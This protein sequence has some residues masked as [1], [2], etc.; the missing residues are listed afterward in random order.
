MYKML[1]NKNAASNH[2]LIKVVKN[3]PALL[4]NQSTT[5]KAIKNREEETVYHTR[6]IQY[7]N[8]RGNNK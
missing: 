6:E 8:N 7:Q 4:K 3:K 5:S 1:T 2:E